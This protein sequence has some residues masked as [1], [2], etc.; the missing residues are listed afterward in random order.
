MLKDPKV[1]CYGLGVTDPKAVFG[2]TTGLEKE[3]GTDR[4]F[5]T[6]FENAK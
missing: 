4:V 3:F 1:L 2:T 6:L 5:D